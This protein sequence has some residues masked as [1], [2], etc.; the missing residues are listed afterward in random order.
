MTLAELPILA[1]ARI[2]SLEGGS[3]DPSRRRLLELGLHPGTEIAVCHRAPLG[4][5]RCY[6]FRSTQM[7]LRRSETS[8]IQVE[9]LSLPA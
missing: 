6:G 2:V 5:P 9:L 1:K 8:R 3:D 4:D 7:C